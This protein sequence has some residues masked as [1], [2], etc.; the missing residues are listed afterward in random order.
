MQ[1][2]ETPLPV[3]IK[4][5]SVASVV[6]AGTAATQSMPRPMRAGT[7]RGAGFSASQRLRAATTQSTPT[8]ALKES[9]SPISSAA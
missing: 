3:T 6:D 4:T 9:S 2:S 1:S 5:G 7:D 8:V